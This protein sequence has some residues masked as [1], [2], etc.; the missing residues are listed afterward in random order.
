[1]ILKKNS[2]VKALYCRFIFL[3][4]EKLNSVA[5]VTENNSL[6]S[7]VLAF[8]KEMK[9]GYVMCIINPTFEGYFNNM[10]LLKCEGIFPTK[11]TIA[12]RNT[13]KVNDTSD[14]KYIFACFTTDKFKVKKVMH[15][16][17]PCKGACDS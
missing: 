8:W 12:F 13:I 16:E 6:K 15:S 3:T 7:F 17:G 4:D 9:L 11:E 5:L 14:E 1:M 2:K 10:P